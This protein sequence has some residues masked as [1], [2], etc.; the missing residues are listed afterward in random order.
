MAGLLAVTRSRPRPLP[1][2][3]TTDD[4]RPTTSNYLPA[5]SGQA[6]GDGLLSPAGSN[7]AG[8]SSVVC[9]R[10]LAVLVACRGKFSIAISLGI[11]VPAIEV[12][13]V[14]RLIFT[15]LLTVSL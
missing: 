11:Q 12:S 9:Q 10:S 13:P 15:R 6:S 1:P 4:R 3:P 8:M 14:E 5:A 7:K 2:G